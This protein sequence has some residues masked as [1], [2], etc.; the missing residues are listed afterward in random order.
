MVQERKCPTC[1]QSM[2]FVKSEKKSIDLSK[3]KKS[4][5]YEDKNVKGYDV[6]EIWRCLNCSEEWEIDI[7]RNIWRKNTIIT[8]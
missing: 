1:G 8:E 6:M 7:Y 2:D 4:N 3:P 5:K